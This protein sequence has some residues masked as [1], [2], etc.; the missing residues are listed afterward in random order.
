LLRR[1]G[2]F[3]DIR[4]IA[5]L[6]PTT[7]GAGEPRLVVSSDFHLT[8]QPG[9][10]L[11]ALLYPAELVPDVWRSVPVSLP[12]EQ[13]GPSRALLDR[14]FTVSRGRLIH[15]VGSLDPRAAEDARAALTK[16]LLG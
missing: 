10:V 14:I 1:T 2:A 6:P 11:T 9:V 4:G 5:R 16:I 15:S 13:G 12:A 3:A 7:V 8:T